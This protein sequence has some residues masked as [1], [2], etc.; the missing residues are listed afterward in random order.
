[1]NPTKA[2]EA[3]NAYIDANLPVMVWGAMGIGKS[4]TIFRIGDDRNWPVRD[5]RLSQIDP[6][7]LRGVPS[8][9]NRRTLWNIPNFLPDPDKEPEGIMFLDEINLAPPSVAAAAYQL[10]LD[11]KVG[12]Y[13]LPEG[14]RIIAAGNRAEDRAQVSKMPAPLCNRFTHIDFEPFLP[15]WVDWANKQGLRTEI[16]SF[17]RFRPELLFDFEGQKN[18]R[19]FPTPRTWSYASRILDVAPQHLEHEMLMSAVGE[20]AAGEFMAYI[21]IYRDLPSIEEIEA[22][23]EAT[24]VPT[25]PASLYATAGMLSEHMTEK[26][27]P[28]VNKYLK[29]LPPEFQVPTVKMAMQ[30]D[31]S[32]LETAE[33]IEW[34]TDNQDILM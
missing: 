21:R 28:N 32:L 6:V 22:R 3:I 5:V 31:N 34:V 24:P 19:A 27:L 16:I 25:E 8:V 29:R 10:V 12:D 30:R 18:V 17:L 4:H 9:E 11:R 26:N 15:D 2:Y 20:E 7:D 1:M 13:E 33:I 14:W 23:P